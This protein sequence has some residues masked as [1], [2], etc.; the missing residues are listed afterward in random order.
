MLIVLPPMA[1]FLL[2]SGGMP[3]LFGATHIAFLLILSV[4]Y[5]L[6]Y[7]FNLMICDKGIKFIL[8]LHQLGQFEFGT[9]GHHVGIFNVI[10]END[11]AG[12]LRIAIVLAGDS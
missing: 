3:F 12:E 1:T 7:V 9:Q 11:I 6:F 4:C 10:E 5:L 2:N 8:F